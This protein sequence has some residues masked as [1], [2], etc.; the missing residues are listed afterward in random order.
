MKILIA[1][2]SGQL[3]CCLRDS[4]NDHELVP[5]NLNELDITRLCQIQKVLARERPEIVLKAAA[6]NDMGGAESHGDAAYAANAMGP[7]NLAAETAEREIPL[8][9]VSAEYVF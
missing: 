7:Q 9:H 8:V 2:A 4:L 6:F 5:L 1:G 3:G